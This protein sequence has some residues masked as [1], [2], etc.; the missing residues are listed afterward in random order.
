MKSIKGTLICCWGILKLSFTSQ[1]CKLISLTN[2]T[3]DV[4]N[5]VILL[6]FEL[7]Q[8][9]SLNNKV[10]QSINIKTIIGGKTVR[11]WYS[12]C[13][14]YEAVGYFEIMVKV[15][16][17]GLMGNHLISLQPGFCVDI[18]QPIGYLS[19]EP[20]DYDNIGI[21][22]GGVGLA[23]M[24]SLMRATLP[25]CPSTKITMIYC[26]RTEG[27]I[28]MR[29]V[30]DNLTSSYETLSIHYIIS[31]PS[32]QWQG[33]KGRI[34]EEIINELLPKDD[35][36]LILYCG[37]PAMNEYVTSFLSKQDRKNVYHA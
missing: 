12:P 26:N 22:C 32:S 34:N 21:I 25:K 16:P 15:Y 29:D 33:R 13:S 2:L 14:S 7:P 4:D 17:G 36:Q 8:G 3:T 37:P 1:K 35:S 24:V 23:P 30:L 9:C 5:P 18:S 27:D 6:R 28:I 19:Y 10:F 20:G 31:Q 11:R